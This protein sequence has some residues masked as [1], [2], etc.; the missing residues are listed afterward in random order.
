MEYALTDW[1]NLSSSATVDLLRSDS[2]RGLNDEQVTNNR[3]T[4]G[5]NII[6]EVKRYEFYKNIAKIFKEPWALML[7]C[8]IAILIFLHSYIEA[9][10]ILLILLLNSIILLS[11]KYENQK[12]LKEIKNLNLGRCSVLRNGNLVNLETAEVVVGDIVIFG[13]GSVIPADIRIISAEDL[14]VNE[15]SITGDNNIVDKYSSKLLETDLSL[16][17]MR[18]ILFK[19]SNVIN[20]SGEGVVVAVGASTEIGKLMQSMMEIDKEENTFNKGIQTIINALCVIFLVGSIFIYIIKLLSK[21]SNYIILKG[22][23]KVILAAVPFGIAI[24]LYFIWLIIKLVNKKEQIHI[25]SFAAIKEL[26]TIDTIL[27]DKEGILTEDTMEVRKIFDLEKIIDVKEKFEMNYNLDRIIEIGVLC[28]DCSQNDEKNSRVDIAEKAIINFANEIDIDSDFL[29]DT[30]KRILKMP[31][32]K[33]RRIKT[34]V[35]HLSKSN[36][37]AYIKG[38][39]D[40]ILSECTHIMKNGVEIEINEDEVNSIKAADIEMSSACL[41]VLAFA[42]RSFKYKP[43]NN[44]NLESNLVFAGLIGFYNPIKADMDSLLSK[45]RLLAVKPIIITEDSKL[46]AMAIGEKY[47]LINLGDLVVSGFEIDNLEQGELQNSIDKFSIFSRIN[48]WHKINIINFLKEKGKNIALTGNKL[49]DLPS[50]RLAKISIAYGQS[51][52]KIVKNLSDVYVEDINLLKIADFLKSSRSIINCIREICKFICFCSL[53]QFLFSAL[54]FLL[55]S[56]DTFSFTQLLWLNLGNLIISSLIIFFNRNN[57]EQDINTNYSIDIKSLVVDK[58]LI[59]Y[60]SVI[61]CAVAFSLLSITGLLKNISIENILFGFFLFA[62][63]IVLYS[64][65]IIKGIKINLFTLFHFIL[66]SAL[67]YYLNRGMVELVSISCAVFV[68]IAIVLLT[69]FLNVFGGEEVIDF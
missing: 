28:N 43:S 30:Q 46:T 24:C 16:S 52:S 38:A 53:S 55:M 1:Y 29:L 22:L 47:N 66:N 18:N 17:E 12:K 33:V 13:R 15:V 6:T 48:N 39:V 3:G 63:T 42:Y 11:E 37:R 45:F 44:E 58:N 21:V 14:R 20:G 59:A 50:L 51:C 61:I 2:N 32:D 34:T 62:E 27:T 25:N 31:Y 35:H 9:A 26:S 19:S 23:E 68:F 36:Y 65:I 5:K 64:K 69:R 41:Y 40:V 4:F 60:F 49:L 57:I 67:I 8:V 7:L 54:A 10:I 56:K